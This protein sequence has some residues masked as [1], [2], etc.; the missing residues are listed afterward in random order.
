VRIG[1]LVEQLP[2]SGNRVSIDSEH[3]DALGLPRPIVDYG[4]DEYVLEGMAAAARVADLLFEQVGIQNRTDP[5]KSFM[6]TATWKGKT[7]PWG[8]AGHFAGTHVMG[9][10][11]STSVVDD[12]QR[13]WDFDNLLVA[14]AGSMPTMGTSNP[15]LTVAALAFRT[16]RDVIANPNGRRAG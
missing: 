15:T 9:T 11:P 4:F 6:A 3:V 7:Y 12:R 2:E 16:A 8:G 1:C 14:G 5:K 10:R 13:S